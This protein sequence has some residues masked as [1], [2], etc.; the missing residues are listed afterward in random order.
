[1]AETIA[2]YGASGTLGRLVSRALAA[3]GVHLRLG[4]RD[5]HK[6]EAAAASLGPDVRWR[7][8]PL[9]A[10][11]ALRELLE[12]CSVVVNAGPTGSGT[13]ELLAA[14]LDVGVHYIDASGAQGHIREIFERYGA[15]AERRGVALVPAFGFD[16]ALGDSLACLVARDHQP[17]REVVIAYA[18]EGSEV[19]GNSLRFAAETPGGGEVVFESGAWVTPRHEFRRRTI[20]FPPPIGV[21]A[22]ARYG[23]GEII[24]VPRH[25]RTDTVTALITTRSLVPHPALIPLF[26]YLRPAVA[27]IRRTP[28]RHLL[29]LAHRGGRTPTSSPEA[30]PRPSRFAI[31]VIVEAPDGSRY[32]GVVEGGDFHRVTVAALSFGARTLASAT[33]DLR[34]AVPPAG[35]CDPAAFLGYLQPLGVTWHVE[36]SDTTRRRP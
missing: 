11:P 20:A 23:S 5:P 36:R 24:T 28:A 6:L 16:Y 7:A 35:V 18:I 32:R 22:V 14:A 13:H 26:P 1:M 12:S 27:V 2:V 19:S 9:N 33:F 8:A 30:A 3:H 21:Q 10:G 17:A 25:T 15:A 4:G 29:R 31:V 34:G